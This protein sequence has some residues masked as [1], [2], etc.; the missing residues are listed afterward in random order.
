MAILDLSLLI[1]V[2]LHYRDGT[3]LMAGNTLIITPARGNDTGEY[4]CTASNK[5]NTTS[6]NAYGN[7]LLQ[8]NANSSEYAQFNTIKYIPLP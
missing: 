7:K 2:F 6:V 1:E 4:T 8:I 5:H 3:H